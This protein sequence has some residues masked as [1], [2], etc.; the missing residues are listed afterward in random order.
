MSVYLSDSELEMIKQRFDAF[1]DH[2]VIDRPLI[3]I[4][5]P[6]AKRSKMNL[7]KP[8]RMEDRWTNIEYV[9]RKALINLEGTLFLGDAVPFY[10]PNLGPDSFTAFLGA[11]L[12]FRSEDTSW[13]K[14]FLEDLSIYEPILKEDNK[15]WRI[16]NSLIDALCE[17]ADERFMIG[18]PD[19]HYG[20]DSLVA[21][22]GAQR[23]IRLLFTQPDEVKR[24]IRR[25]TDICIQV[26]E[27]Y[28]QKI[29]RV[30]EG[31]ITWIPAYSRGR[32]FALQDDFS[33]LV[34]PRMFEDFFVEEQEII[35][36]HLDNSIFHL[37]GPMALG[38]LN[39]LL[40][41]ESLDGIQWVPGVGAKPMSRWLDVCKKV[42][43]VGK[44]LQ[45]SCEPEEVDFLLSNLKHEG[46]FISTHCGSEREA[47]N[48]LKIAERHGK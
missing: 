39:R 27:R 32:F 38:N 48:V 5:A 37:D 4:T 26:F 19:I 40:Q 23:L 2:E 6:K 9:V 34:S 25:L 13:A 29:S 3:R 30:Q 7:A 8:E 15:W 31:S 10:M 24:I 28:Y 14:P 1:W 35:S 17:V 16:M 44:C 43:D 33:G 36:R 22:V 12:T 47:W 45:I 11:D 20:G 21:T 42:L 18:I 41:I 46:L